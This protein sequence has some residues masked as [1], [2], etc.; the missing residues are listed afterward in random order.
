MPVVSVRASGCMWCMA[1]KKAE[2]GRAAC[3]LLCAWPTQQA[4][5][6]TAALPRRGTCVCGCHACMY[7]RK[8]THPPHFC[9]AQPAA[10]PA[11]LPP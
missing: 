1:A 9:A 4:P 11:G 3:T 6:D 5:A 2:V 8:P 10:R 7:A